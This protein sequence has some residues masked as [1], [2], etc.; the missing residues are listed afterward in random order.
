MH[1]FRSCCKDEVQHVNRL[2]PFSQ[3]SQRR[4]QGVESNDVWRE[5]HRSHSIKRSAH[6]SVV[7]TFHVASHDGVEGGRRG[8]CKRSMQGEH[9]MESSHSFFPLP[10]FNQTFHVHIHAGRLNVQRRLCGEPF[11]NLVQRRG[12]SSVAGSGDDGAEGGGVAV[13][14]L[15]PHFFEDV[16]R[17]P[18]LKGIHTGFEH[19]VVGDGV[20]AEGGTTCPHR[21]QEVQTFVE[22]RVRFR[23]SVGGK[24]SIAAHSI[25]SDT[26]SV[27]EIKHGSTGRCICSRNRGAATAT[28][29]GAAGVI[30][31]SGGGG[32]GGSSAFQVCEGR[33][34][35]MEVRCSSDLCRGADGICTT[36]HA[37]LQ[38]RQR[39]LLLWWRWRWWWCVVETR[40]GGGS[41]R[42]GR[43]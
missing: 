28:A 11:A 10:D 7:S 42:R 1:T 16:H 12:V 41:K 30:L 25:G 22:L 18:Q 43:N 34:C 3:S 24:K 2:T 33:H 29:V 27:R 26:R 36:D 23:S 40:G 19:G 9:R 31:K 8:P 14:A 13:D 20:G 5:A 21:L 39:L 6:F 37:S 35:S 4:Q 17:F 32:G 38:P 15:A